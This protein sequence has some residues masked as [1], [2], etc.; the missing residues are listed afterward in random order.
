M[1]CAQQWAC[2]REPI[3]I[4]IWFM[5]KP[6]RKSEHWQARRA[7][8]WT[9]LQTPGSTGS[10]LTL[11]SCFLNNTLSV[12]LLHQLKRDNGRA[13]PN[14]PYWSHPLKPVSHCHYVYLVQ[15]W[16]YVNTR[17]KCQKRCVFFC[18]ISQT[19]YE[20]TMEEVRINYAKNMWINVEDEHCM[21]LIELLICNSLVIS[22]SIT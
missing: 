3:W 12:Q 20:G 22:V 15:N 7:P 21:N 5:T 16:S 8:S 11:F 18:E 9:G 2:A 10:N 13:F 4:S 19:Y 17:G 6:K 1:A 14:L